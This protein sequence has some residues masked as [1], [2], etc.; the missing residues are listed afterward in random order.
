MIRNSGSRKLPVLV[1]FLGIAALMLRKRLYA[2]AVDVKGLLIQNHPLEIA[3][4]V[5]TGM[6]LL[7]AEEGIID[8]LDGYLTLKGLRLLYERNR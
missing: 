8:K 3:L 4:F 1:F 7:V 5:L 6:A 2:V